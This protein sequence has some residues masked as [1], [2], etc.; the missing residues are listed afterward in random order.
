[1]KIFCGSL[2]LS[3][4]FNDFNIPFIT[5]ITHGEFSYTY[6]L[7]NK[8]LVDRRLE[9]RSERIRSVFSILGVAGRF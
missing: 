1:M 8:S 5:L 3:V 7:T 9:R 6:Y 2:G 4:L